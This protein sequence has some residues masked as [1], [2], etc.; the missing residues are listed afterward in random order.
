MI[1]YDEGDEELL[2]TMM[3]LYLS[4][5][6]MAQLLSLA[7]SLTSFIGDAVVVLFVC[8]IVPPFICANEIGVCSSLL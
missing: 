8:G 2:V 3:H 7:I 4:S 5:C 1:V 6:C